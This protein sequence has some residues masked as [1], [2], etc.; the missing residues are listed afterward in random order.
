M[1]TVTVPHLRFDF[2]ITQLRKIALTFN[3]YFKRNRLNLYIQ[4]QSLLY[5]IPI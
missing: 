3:L 4:N 1:T 5:N 2:I